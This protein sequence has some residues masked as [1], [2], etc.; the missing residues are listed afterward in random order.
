MILGT[1]NDF[2][3]E[4][5][6]PLINKALNYIKK[7][8]WANVKP[9]SYEID[10][11]NMFAS[12][13]EVTTLDKKEKKAEQHAR[14]ID[15]QYLVSGKETIY[16]A[17]PSEENVITENKMESQDVAFYNEVQ[18]ESELNLIPGTFAILFPSDIHTP[19]CSKKEKMNIKKVII[20]IKVSR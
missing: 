13:Q 18:N 19:G 6:S 7:T 5:F 16:V 15:L 10:G 2:E 14:Y 12:V 4:W 17:R 1:I 9:G 11:D 3:Q 8:D 20:K